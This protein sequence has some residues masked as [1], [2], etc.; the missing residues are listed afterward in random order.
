MA[1][2]LFAFASVACLAVS[3]AAFMACANGDSSAN[4]GGDGGDDGTISGEGGP[5][6]DGGTSESGSSGGD[7]GGV[8]LTKACADNAAQYC[9][10]LAKC[11]P[12]L[13]SLQYGDMPTCQVQLGDPYCHDIVTAK[14]SGWTGAGLEACITARTKLTCAEFLYDK[15]GPTACRPSGT[16]TSGS[17]LWD[18][19]C[20]AG[21]CRVPSGSLCGNCVQRGNTGASC[22]TSNDCDG[23]LLC[24][25]S[26]CVAPLPLG[27]VC[28]AGMTPCEYGLQCLAG[29]CAAPGGVGA[30]CDADGGGTDCD[31]NLGAYCDAGTCT[32]IMVS[33]STGSCGGS[34]PSV[35]YGDGV[36]QGGF[37]VPP[38]ANGASCMAD[39]GTPCTTPS[40]CI[41]GTCS[42][43]TSAA[44]P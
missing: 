35:C 13:L 6:D 43:P 10:Q 40:Q 3:S 9:T 4:P 27:G 19:Q 1:R 29:K 8:S 2:A 42:T 16:I 41:G 12:F 15:P 31:Y 14:G 32:A 39:G 28:T 20:G 26:A 23:D 33:M 7:G 34:P 44:C 22:A 11:S 30:S 38:T 21:Y 36:C 18:S 24:F 37:C 5:G 17:C 25:Q